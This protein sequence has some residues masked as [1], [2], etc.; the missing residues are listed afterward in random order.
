MTADFAFVTAFVKII[1]IKRRKNR[2]FPRKIRVI[3]GQNRERLVYYISV[4]G[5]FS[6]NYCF[7]IYEDVKPLICVKNIL[8]CIIISS[9]EQNLS[10]S[11]WFKPNRTKCNNKE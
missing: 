7:K 9:I 1:K 5:T 4:F 2:Q 10:V 3:L 11:A 6:F 8:L